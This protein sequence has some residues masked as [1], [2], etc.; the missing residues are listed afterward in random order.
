[1]GKC[2]NH[3][4]TFF[5]E[6]VMIKTQDSQINDDVDC[7]TLCQKLGLNKHRQYTFLITATDKH[8]LFARQHQYRLSTYSYNR[9]NQQQ[10]NNYK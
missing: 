3:L 2:E 7:N 10:N 6:A 8:D 5:K 9:K 4:E 1:M